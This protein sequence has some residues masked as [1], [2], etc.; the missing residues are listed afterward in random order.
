LLAFALILDR[1]NIFTHPHLPV[2]SQELQHFNRWI[3]VTVLSTTIIGN[4]DFHFIT[5]F[6]GTTET[7]NFGAASRLTMPIT[8]LVSALTITLLPKLS[9]LTTIEAHQFFVR[10]LCLVLPIAVLAIIVA[11]VIGIPALGMLVEKKYGGLE[12]LMFLQLASIVLVLIANPFGMLLL[13]RGKTKI[14][15]IT[16]LGQLLVDI[17]LNSFFI[18]RFGAMGAVYSTIT[19]NFMGLIIFVLV[20]RKELYR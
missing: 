11:G 15:A 14:L 17:V 9:K 18:P 12:S 1:K 6:C 2:R 3:L 5:Y 13:A 20:T 7:A 8:M 4:I 16:N 19:I 10:K